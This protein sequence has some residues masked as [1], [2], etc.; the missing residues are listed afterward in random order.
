MFVTESIQ[1]NIILCKTEVVNF[2]LN[3]QA[4]EYLEHFV[5]KITQL[6]LFYVY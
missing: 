3:R 5:F 1:I 2:F 4:V 6:P